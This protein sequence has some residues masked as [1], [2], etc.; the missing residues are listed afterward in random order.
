MSTLREYKNP[1][2]PEITHYRLIPPGTSIHLMLGT[3]ILEAISLYNFCKSKIYFQKLNSVLRKMITAVK[4]NYASITEY[5]ESLCNI[6]DIITKEAKTVQKSLTW[7][8]GYAQDNQYNRFISIVFEHI[9][10]I[11]CETLRN[12][13]FNPTM[14]DEV[15][16]TYSAVFNIKIILF[17]GYGYKKCFSPQ[18]QG[19]CPMIYLLHHENNVIPVYGNEMIQFETGLEAD[20]DMILLN[21]PMV[22]YVLPNPI[23]GTNNNSINYPKPEVSHAPFGNQITQGPKMINGKVTNANPNQPFSNLNPQTT[24]PIM[25]NSGPKNQ[26][27]LR[28]VQ[29][30]PNNT[31]PIGFNNVHQSILPMPAPPSR[32]VQL[33]SVP[34]LPNSNLSP[35]FNPAQQSN[36][37]RINPQFANSP[38]NSLPSLGFNSGHQIIAPVPNIPIIQNIEMPRIDDL[39]DNKVSKRTDL[40]MLHLSPAATEELKC[41]YSHCIGTTRCYNP[42]TAFAEALQ[43]FFS[44]NSNKEIRKKIL[45]RFQEKRTFSNLDLKKSYIIPKDDRE[46]L[47]KVLL[48]ISKV[49]MKNAETIDEE[50]KEYKKLEILADNESMFTR[51]SDGPHPDFFL[52][53]VLCK[54]FGFTAV[55]IEQKHRN[56]DKFQRKQVNGLRLGYRPELH[57]ISLRTG[58]DY[59]HLHVLITRKH[60]LEDGFSITEQKAATVRTV[61]RIITNRSLESLP[62]SAE[63]S[64]E[65]YIASLID[66]IK[67]QNQGLECL[68]TSID[69]RNPIMMDAEDIDAK[70]NHLKVFAQDANSASFREK[71]QFVQPGILEYSAIYYCQV[72][73]LCNNIGKG[74]ADTVWNIG[75]HYHAECIESVFNAWFFVSEIKPIAELS[76]PCQKCRQLIRL[77]TFLTSETGRKFRERCLQRFDNKYSCSN[78]HE[79]RDISEVTL[80]DYACTSHLCPKCL[81]IKIIRKENEY[82]CNG[83]HLI[84]LPLPSEALYECVYC[85]KDI[86]LCNFIEYTDNLLGGIACKRC[87]SDWC[88]RGNYMQHSFSLETI[89][90]IF[91]SEKTFCIM[92][93]HEEYRNYTGLICPGGCRICYK[94]FNR[95]KCAGCG[96]ALVEDQNRLWS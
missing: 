35:H 61:S 29:A 55:V 50:T 56:S 91:D 9:F 80:H 47:R 77:E 93:R 87:W 96:V 54:I 53:T 52:L 20:L 45:K 51:I 13:N 74:P 92:C 19:N 6:V 63:I 78:C 85:H 75:C 59:N 2:L 12:T 15:L 58:D 86:L 11:R 14:L 67:L 44:L 31:S 8:S 94:H 4:A 60:A 76:F 71:Y 46:E 69:Q 73:E 32:S 83:G 66:I 16:A 48:K 40:S 89:T 43:Q 38:N 41:D 10:W 37:P 3:R 70:R 81:A 82:S 7:I 90:A 24:V 49:A 28:P 62:N 39:P 95:D 79:I 68:R 33:P 42:I 36:P 21:P 26:P 72:C 34:N 18:L 22:S 17:L 64:E 27:A 65:G 25:K 88:L 1:Q 84:T 30:M 23:I 5:L 57:F